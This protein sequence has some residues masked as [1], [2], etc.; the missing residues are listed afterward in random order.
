MKYNVLISVAAWKD[1]IKR[2]KETGAG[3]VIYIEQ[4]IPNPEVDLF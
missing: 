4:C 2:G 1:K 3:Y